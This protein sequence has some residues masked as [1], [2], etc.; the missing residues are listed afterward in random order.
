MT[1]LELRRQS[2]RKLD[3][4]KRKIEASI[5]PKLDRI[6]RNM[7]DDASNLYK[8]TGNVPS[9]ELAINYE[10]EFL[11]EI[12]DAMRKS[13]R[14]FGFNLRKTIE[15]KHGLFFDAELKSQW[16]ELDLKQSI[17]IEDEDIDD[18]LEEINNQFLIES[19]TF[20]AN[21]SENQNGYVTETNTKMIA[22]A[23]AAGIAAFST[24]VTG[25]Q[26]EAQDLATRLVDAPLS[27]R[28]GIIR[29]IERVNRQ[30]EASNR[31]QRAIVS[32]NIR[33]NLLERAPARSELIAAQNVGLAESWARQTEAE[34][35]DDANLISAQG[36]PVR[37]GKSWQAILD[38]RTRPSHV[39]ADNQ[40]VGVRQNFIVGGEQ[41]RYPR[42]PNGSAG[43]VI[44]CRCV[45]DFSV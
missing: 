2:A 33:T 25:L 13:I 9:Q 16:I 42:D 5:T 38:S 12:R 26:N 3:I 35:I 34:L 20:V 4:E 14:Q 45:S 37:V 18:K 44:N 29:Q 21:E 19:T 7:A 27:E 10:P 28:A 41:L 23:V 15:K 31:N 8:A 30:I 1:T 32:E 22:A 6:F 40:E 39:D 11:K 24:Q 36:Q 43:N 17:T